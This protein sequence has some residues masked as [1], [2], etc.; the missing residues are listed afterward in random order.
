[1]AIGLLSIHPVGGD[2]LCYANLARRFSPEQPFYGIRATN[3]PTAGKPAESV[4]DLAIRYVREIRSFQPKGP[5]FLG[6]YSFGGSVALEMAQELHAQGQHVA[7]LA[8]LDHTPP[9][10]RYC[11]AIRRPSFLIEFIRN[12][13]WWIADDLLHYGVA[14]VL[15][16]I[17]LRARAA[18]ARMTRLVTRDRAKFSAPEVET[19]FDL[20]RMPP[21]FQ[22]VLEMHYKVL[23]SY[24]AR[25]YPGS[26]VLFRARTRPLF[27]LYGDDLGWRGI[28]SGGLTICVV[29]GNHETILKEP[30][31]GYL[32][33]QLEALLRESQSASKQKD[34]LDCRDALALAS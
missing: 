21:D 23:R 10:I 11:S 31:V 28:A 2:V 30:N 6:G 33:E 8:I 4:R 25:V 24:Q 9:P 27:R 1:V 32:A 22:R 16:R 20:S 13:P 14:D 26:V 7:L 5:Y 12:A 29:P 18:M 19:L 34:G 17:R 3:L 15:G